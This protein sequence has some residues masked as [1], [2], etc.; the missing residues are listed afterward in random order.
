[1]SYSANRS[2]LVAR[3]NL[4]DSP[5]WQRIFFCAVNWEH[6]VVIHFMILKRLK[7]NFLLVPVIKRCIFYYDRFALKRLSLN[8]GHFTVVRRQC[9]FRFQSEL[10]VRRVFV[11]HLNCRGTFNLIFILHQQFICVLIGT[12]NFLMWSLFSAKRAW[13][14]KW[15]FRMKRM[16]TSRS[17]NS[18]YS[19]LD[20]SYS[21]VN[22]IFKLLHLEDMFLLLSCDQVFHVNQHYLITYLAENK[23]AL[24]NRVLPKHRGH[25]VNQWVVYSIFELHL[26]N[27]LL[28]KQQ[29]SLVN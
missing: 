16:W 26:I 4:N 9:C 11:D 27:C 17:L 15:L 20:A 28:L 24:V 8:M 3:V 21:F 1:M 5:V 12:Y 6:F 29:I 18:S 23:R 19:I 7:L 14:W 10:H 22:L 2:K 13:K 25:P